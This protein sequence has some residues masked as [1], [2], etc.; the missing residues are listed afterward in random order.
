[1]RPN[2]RALTVATVVA[3]LLVLTVPAFAG[4]ITNTSAKNPSPISSTNL[5]KAASS[6]APVHGPSP[7][8]YFQ[9]PDFNG[10]FSSQ[11][12][13]NSFGNFATAFD[14]F[15]LGASYN[16]D[17]IQ[18][19]GSYFNPPAQGVITAFT[20]TFYADNA[21][22]PG[23]ALAVYNGPGNFGETFLGFDNAGDPTFLYTGFLGT[24]FAAA[25]GTQ[26]WLSIVPDLGF[27]PQWGW[28]TGTGGDGAAY[29]CFFGS[30]G[31]VGSDL[32]FALYG[33][34]PEPGTLVLLG[35][36]LLGLAGVIRRKMS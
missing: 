36:G 30:C 5:P 10:A 33:T 16:L 13:T 17:E 32:S 8:V 14:N 28:E 11:N 35:T 22:T 26:Y 7:I 21:G 20:A 31:P 19:I 27:P 9:N 6:Y 24:P 3:C 4:M 15:T 23:A 1:M 34:T 2:L 25:A 12:D 18:W 29:Q